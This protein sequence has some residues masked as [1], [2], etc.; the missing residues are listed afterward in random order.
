MHVWRAIGWCVT[1]LA[2]RL[3]QWRPSYTTADL[4]LPFLGAK[5]C[6]DKRPLSLPI[7]FPLTPPSHANNHTLSRFAIDSLSISGQD[8]TAHR[9]EMAWSR[10]GQVG[11]SSACHAPSSSMVGSISFSSDSFTIP[12]AIDCLISP[13]IEPLHRLSIADQ[14]GY[15]RSSRLGACQTSS[16]KRLLSYGFTRDLSSDRAE[17]SIFILN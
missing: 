5:S 13:A 11:G 8:Q 9:S 1:K 10:C 15:L 14:G 7:P 12:L 17:N 3:H 4:H 16:S 6:I 2:G